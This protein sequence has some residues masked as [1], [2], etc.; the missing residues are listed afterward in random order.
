MKNEQYG[1]LRA[2][3][4]RKKKVD[5]W[6]FYSPF[7]DEAS[8]KAG[9]E[10]VV[11]MRNGHREGLHFVAISKHF[12]SPIKDEN[13]KRL[14]EKVERAFQLADVAAR[15]IDWEDWIEIEIDQETFWK[16]QNGAGLTVQWQLI[17]RGVHPDSGR[18]YTINNN[19]VVVE[20]PK[21]KLAG[22]DDEPNTPDG[23]AIHHRDVDKQFSYIPATP[24]NIAALKALTVR[25]T[26]ARARVQALLS[27]AAVQQTL[28]DVTHLRLEGP[29]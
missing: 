10:A 19:N 24:A 4:H 13:I 16:G 8:R 27:Q 2:K 7:A 22:E 26:E 25:I 29:K 11:E 3:A 21:A 12:G 17:K 1:A 14:R 15:R 6:T 23:W 28:A 5:V 18:A 9:Y 20:F